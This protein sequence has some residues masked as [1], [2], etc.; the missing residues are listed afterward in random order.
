M[1]LLP[2]N[3]SIL[4]PS[5]SKTNKSAK[6][7][8]TVEV[9]FTIECDTL[10]Q[11]NHIQEIVIFFDFSQI[12]D[13]SSPVAGKLKRAYG[14]SWVFEPEDLEDAESSGSATDNK[15]DKKITGSASITAKCTGNLSIGVAYIDENGHPA[16]VTNATNSAQPKNQEEFPRFIYVEYALLGVKDLENYFS[17]RYLSLIH[18]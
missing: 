9:E 4:Q 6:G 15:A 12:A 8:G 2:Q 18:I 1:T 7:G 5:P 3:G 14:E 13:S 17:S 11:L 10:D 16:D